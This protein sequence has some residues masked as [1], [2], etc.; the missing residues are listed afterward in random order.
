MHTAALKVEKDTCPTEFKAV[1]IYDDIGHAARAA[2]ALERATASAG[3]DLNCDLK[4]WRLEALEHPTQSAI[5][6]AVAANA[7]LIVFALHDE[8]PSLEALLDW[9]AD[10]AA[11]R[12]IEDA[13]VTSLGPAVD[14][15]MP[16]QIGLDRFARRHGLAFFGADEARGDEAWEAG[17]REQWRRS[18]QAGSRPWPAAE[19]MPA[20]SHWGIND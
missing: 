6:M 1:I 19:P 16:L 14:T 9:L 7:N 17:L 5:C 15:A 3:P 10:W 13:A 11:N 8:P 4:L 2:A 12:R 18:P 20:A